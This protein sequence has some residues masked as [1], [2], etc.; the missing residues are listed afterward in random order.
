MAAL[1]LYNDLDGSSVGPWQRNALN[2]VG[3]ACFGWGSASI[4]LA[5]YCEDEE[6]LRNWILLTAAVVMTTIHAQDLPDIAG[7]KVRGR[8]TIPLV[9]GDSWA[10]WSI[11]V[12]VPTWSMICL[13]FWQVHALG[14]MTLLFIAGTMALLVI[15]RRDHS[16]D[17]QVWRLWCLW[18]SALYFLPIFG[19]TR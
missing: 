13:N 17:K 5:G 12:L 19:Q 7:D 4:L 11:A 2:A 8:R 10:R 16:S 14:W 9:Y 15:L 1:W 18:M 6:L 3:L